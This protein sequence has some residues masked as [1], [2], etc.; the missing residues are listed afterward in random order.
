MKKIFMSYNPFKLE[1]DIREGEENG[2]K[3]DPSSTVFENKGKRLQLWVN[4]FTQK[5]HEAIN[6]D[7]KLV[8]KGTEL[9]YL[10]LKEDVDSFNETNKT[11]NIKVELEHE[12]A[13]SSEDRLEDL[14]ELFDYMQN[15]S[16]FDD[17]K[18]DRVIE[19][20]NKAMGSEF[21]V[22]V[23]ATMSSGKSTLLNALLGMELMPS[24][25][26]ACTATIARI[27]D[28]SGEYFSAL[29]RDKDEN[30]IIEE[31][32]KV[33]ADTISEFNSNRDV[34][35][36]DI[37]GD[38]PF[39]ESHKIQL[40]LL[41][42]PGPNNSRDEKHKEKT[43]SV[44]KDSNPM[45][46]YVL[47]ATQLS[48][49]DDNN[50]LNA[51]SEAMNEGGKQSRDRFMFVVNKVDCFD[52]EKGESVE[53]VLQN[54]IDYLSEHGIE[55]PNIYLASSEMAKVIRLHKNNYELSRKQ[56]QTYNN[57]ELFVEDEELHLEKYAPLSKMGKN[58]LK[59]FKEN[60]KNEEDLALIH[61]GI[62]V[63]EIAINEYLEKYAI[64][65][66]VEQAVSTFIGQIN[67]KNIE[68]ELVNS[69][70]D[71][72]EKL[73][74]FHDKIEKISGQIKEGEKGK[75]FKKRIEKLDLSEKTKKLVDDLRQN[76]NNK[77]SK[78]KPDDEYGGIKEAK[79]YVRNFNSKIEDLQPKIK[80]E[81]E[82]IINKTIKESAEKYIEEYK[83][84]IASMLE[85]LNIKEFNTEG[86]E[87]NI[88]YMFTD[89][90]K[91][92]NDML[93]D[94][95]E[96]K[97]VKV[98]TRTVKDSTWWKPWTWGRTREEN[99]YESI[100]MVNLDEFF[101]E[102]AG[103]IN[104]VFNKSI[105]AAV[106]EAKRVSEEFKEYFKEEIDKL[107]KLLK[108]KV[109]ELEKITSSKEEI[110]KHKEENEKNQNWLNDFIKRLNKI[111]EI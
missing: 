89:G 87:I 14:K 47:N 48:T 58:K 1:L 19:N 25:N 43:Y 92:V 23:I 44:I 98:D 93:F 59:E 99:V 57:L 91:N 9:D 72:E 63:I 105:E 84:Y 69:I 76:V 80:V 42:T 107:E 15:T 88:S 106:K 33:S 3:F 97:K 110:E 37:K 108:D 65:T 10:D 83:K 67:S 39:L 94:F 77:I 40:V 5:L 22:A 29:C 79:H 78:L 82:Y 35:Y 68:G 34:S 6:D 73:K 74:D 95:K 41:D 96:T 101:D 13:K 31:V 60:G 71:N 53:K 36:I 55:N 85:E 17:L 38:I 90:L 66:K 100:E 27:K 56:K 45:V 4:G 50:L 21:E 70:K 32:K 52:T 30:I 86:T 18:E 102:A 12:K 24:K 11:N 61:T 16:P 75:E 111:L 109:D 46:I 20:F 26:E 7:F 49:N 2:N 103:E 51:V 54:V 104:I 28:D 81:L 8:F 64:T 62:P